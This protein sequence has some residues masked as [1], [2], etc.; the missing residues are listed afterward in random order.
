MCRYVRCLLAFGAETIQRPIDGV[1]PYPHND[2]KGSVP[3]PRNGHQ[4]DKD[5]RGTKVTWRK[6]P[7]TLI[8]VVVVIAMLGAACGGG[9]EESANTSIT[10][11]PASSTTA[12]APAT[13]T[14][15]HPWPA[16]G[17]EL[18]AQLGCEALS[19]GP[20]IVE[21]AWVLQCDTE[22]APE[23]RI[24]LFDS[25]DQ[26]ARFLNFFSP[27]QLI[28]G[29]GWSVTTALEPFSSVDEVALAVDG[30]VV[31]RTAPGAED[32]FDQPPLVSDAGAEMGISEALDVHHDASAL[33]QGGDPMAA[34]PMLNRIIASLP[35][36]PM[37]R[38]AGARALALN[39]RG[40]AYE[41]L[42]ADPPAP[43]IAH[44]LLDEAAVSYQWLVGTYAAVLADQGVNSLVTW[45]F[46]QLGLLRYR[47]Y[48][49]GGAIDFFEK[50][51]TRATSN[52]KDAPAI[53]DSMLIRAT[54]LADLGDLDAGAKG[55][56]ELIDRFENL[57]NPFIQSIV[58]EAKELLPLMSG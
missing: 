24:V 45:G 26:Q 38:A 58:E 48:D 55:L 46:Y 28:V 54:L 47:D 42:E 12:T 9:A 5:P 35:D 19:E 10:Q 39:S 37:A 8:A 17:D 30:I 44:W 57:P 41:A 2:W 56:Q 18:A 33:S 29:T 23:T 6:R 25:N 32:P 22:F 40:L 4:L 31:K 51:I 16:L 11:P 21:T 7:A 15:L 50:A 14:T 52:P 3:W 49:D 53:A 20:N 1:V 34:I 43:G 36:D 27:T 13:T